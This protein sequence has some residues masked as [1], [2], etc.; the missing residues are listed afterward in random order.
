MKALADAL[1]AARPD[2][3]RRTACAAALE[4][5]R[6]GFPN[7]Q[8]APGDPALL[9]VPTMCENLARLDRDPV[10]GPARALGDVVTR[11]LV[12]WHHSQQGRHRGIGLYY[13]PV[14]PEHANRSHLYNEGLAETD[15]AQLPA[16]GAEPGHGVGSDR[17][18]S[19]A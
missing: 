8:A 6:I 13:R 2:A 18:R 1:D 16:A 10:A 17:A 15:A 3:A 19:A 11:R 7:D 14:K 4:A 12:T 9:D 5:A